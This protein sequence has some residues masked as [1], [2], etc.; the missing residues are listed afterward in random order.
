MFWRMMALAAALIGTLKI[1]YST[2]KRNP[3]GAFRNAPGIF[4]D[5]DNRV[6][7]P[8]VIH[9]QGPARSSSGLR[10]APGCRR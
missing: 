10:G 7:P 8:V 9:F 5:V 4:D 1:E 2:L 3:S 6:T